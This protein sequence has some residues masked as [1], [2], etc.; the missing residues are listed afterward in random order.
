LGIHSQEGKLQPVQSPLKTL[1]FSGAIDVNTFPEWADQAVK[2]L[3]NG[4]LLLIPYAAH[5]PTVMIS[6]ASQIM[7][8]YFLADGDMSKVPTDCIGQL[9]APA[10]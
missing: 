8:D 10:W 7:S 1:L 6:C 9:K 2:T 3:A 5:E 4:K